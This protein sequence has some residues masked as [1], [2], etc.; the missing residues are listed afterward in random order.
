MSPKFHK[1]DFIMKKTIYL[2]L[3]T[4]F[5]S[6]FS[7]PTFAKNNQRSPLRVLFIGNSFTYFCNT[8]EIFGLLCKS[9]KIPVEIES[10]TPGGY[11]FAQHAKNERTQ[12]LLSQKWDWVILQAQS[13]EPVYRKNEVL[14]WGKHLIKKAMDNGAQVLLFNTW[15]YRQPAT[16]EFDVDMHNKICQTYCELALATKC[17]LAPCGPAWKVVNEKFPQLDLYNKGDSNCHPSLQGAYLNACIFFTMITGKSTR[18][19]PELRDRKNPKLAV[20]GKKATIL[21]KVAEQTVKTFSP[22]KFLKQIN[23]QNQALPA[24][25]EIK[26]ELT[27]GMTREDAEKIL[28]TSFQSNPESR[29][30][31]YK[32]RNDIIIWVTYN[33]DNK[34]ISAHANDWALK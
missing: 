18:N 24:F 2:F 19:L 26:K 33:S 21:Q 14:H 16:K 22:E 11:G 31:L 32:A 34:I 5:I 29:L 4:L 8:P 13:V 27:M 9:R 6:F 7:L 12:Q 3:V 25:D 23:A 15:G 1:E 20:T 10:S 30:F 28:G 17:K